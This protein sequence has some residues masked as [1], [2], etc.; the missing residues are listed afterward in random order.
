MMAAA[1]LPFLMGSSCSSTCVNCDILP[2]GPSLSPPIL[3][4]Y[5]R[6]VM[7]NAPCPAGHQ[8]MLEAQVLPKAGLGRRGWGS[9]G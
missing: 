5:C 3:P 9:G 8:D 6:T 1:A 4:E 7:V 2:W